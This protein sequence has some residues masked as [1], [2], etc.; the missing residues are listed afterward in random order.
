MLVKIKLKT[1]GVLIS[2]VLIGSDLSNDEFVSVN[3]VLKEYN[4]IKETIRN[5]E[6]VNSDE[7]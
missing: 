1:I 7:T 4:G 2:N 3:D 6:S 5:H